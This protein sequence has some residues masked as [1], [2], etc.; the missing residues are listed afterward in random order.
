MSKI[1]NLDKYR[2]KKQE[3]KKNEN[4]LIDFDQLYRDYYNSQEFKDSLKEY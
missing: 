4:P 2:K 1:I 3:Q